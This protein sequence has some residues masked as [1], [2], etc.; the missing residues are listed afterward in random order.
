MMG[1]ARLV[2]QTSATMLLETLSPLVAGGTSNVKPTTQLR[3]GFAPGQ[4]QQ[5][6]L[7]TDGNKGA[8]TP[9]HG[10][11]VPTVKSSNCS[12]C[13]VHAL[14]TMSCP[15]ARE[16][17]PVGIKMFK[18]KPRDERHPFSLACCCGSR[19]RAPGK[20]PENFLSTF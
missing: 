16:P 12:R 1:S 18:Q 3:E 15:S 4:R 6:K 19:S 10:P 2:G 8:S 5:H 13:P 7:F 11:I 9:R 17:Q 20:F 14:F